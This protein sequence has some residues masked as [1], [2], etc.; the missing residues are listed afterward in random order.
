M[1]KNNEI[2]EKVFFCEPREGE[3]NFALVVRSYLFLDALN[4]IEGV[5]P[6][7]VAVGYWEAYHRCYNKGWNINQED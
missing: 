4:R 7:D 2:A 5:G 3:V 1:D 6:R